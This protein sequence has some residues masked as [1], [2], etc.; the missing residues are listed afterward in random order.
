MATL[1]IIEWPAM[2][3]ETKAEPVKKFDAELKQFVADMFET[4]RAASGIGLAANQVNVLKRVLTISIPFNENRYKDLEEKQES[5]HNR[6]W[7]FIN[8]EITKREGK[9]CAQE[10]CL[11]FPEIFDNVD[12]AAEVWVKAFDE[13]GKPFEVHANGLFSICLQHEIDHLDGIVFVNRMSRLKANMIRKKM[14]KRKV[15]T[16]MEEVTS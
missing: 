2:V 5:W 7:V 10:G 12:R 14:L 1:P 9:I 6:D 16:S 8:P 3:L 11:S 13:N 15:P 4:M